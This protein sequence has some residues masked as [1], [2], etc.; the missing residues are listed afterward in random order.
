MLQSRCR[1]QRGKAQKANASLPFQA[2]APSATAS[3]RPAASGR[4]RQNTGISASAYRNRRVGNVCR[5]E[6]SAP[7]CCMRD[8]SIVAVDA[9]RLLRSTKTSTPPDMQGQR[10]RSVQPE[11]VCVRRSWHDTKVSTF[12]PSNSSRTVASTLRCRHQAVFPRFPADII[13]SGC[14]SPVTATHTSATSCYV[15]LCWDGENALVPTDHR[16]R[17]KNILR[18]RSGAARVRSRA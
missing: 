11:A 18:V 12:I 7:V 17:S 15:R 16:D 5:R 10:Y 3:K 13:R 1:P 14:V 4:A 2:A 8:K 9:C 6:T